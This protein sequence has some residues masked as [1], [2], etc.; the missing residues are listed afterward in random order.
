MPYQRKPQ[1]FN[2]MG[3]ADPQLF[4][5][6]PFPIKRE[7]IFLS[8]KD[9]TSKYDDKALANTYAENGEQTPPME[10]HMDQNTIGGVAG[11]IKDKRDRKL[12][13]KKQST[14]PAKAQLVEK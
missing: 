11:A 13:A 6:R 8:D 5:A 14:R 7:P 9:N 1:V 2:F 10:S 4:I 3:G 12:E